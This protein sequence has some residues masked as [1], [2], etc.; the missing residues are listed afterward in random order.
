MPLNFLISSTQYSLRS[1]AF[2]VITL[3]MFC[4]LGVLVDSLFHMK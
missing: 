4:M 1:I 3:V 2:C